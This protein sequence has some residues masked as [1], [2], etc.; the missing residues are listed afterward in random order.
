MHLAVLMFKGNRLVIGS[1]G[2]QID[3]LFKQEKLMYK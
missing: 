2:L 3:N 1:R